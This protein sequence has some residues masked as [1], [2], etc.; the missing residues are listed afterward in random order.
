MNLLIEC[1]LLD[2]KLISVPDGNLY[3]D[4][5]WFRRIPG[6]IDFDSRIQTFQ[7]FDPVTKT[8]PQ[9]FENDTI[10]VTHR[11]P[12][13][14]LENIPV[15][16]ADA[17][18]TVPAGEYKQ[19]NQIY[20]DLETVAGG[21]NKDYTLTVVKN[22]AGAAL[23]NAMITGAIAVVPAT[24]ASIAMFQNGPTWLNN[25]GV[26][27]NED[28]NIVGTVLGPGD[29]I[30]GTWTNKVADDRCRLQVIAIDVTNMTV[31]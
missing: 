1:F 18:Y 4:S 10:K 21:A 27:A 13:E 7:L 12:L 22:I 17:I 29:T 3:D 24:D 11:D 5:R 16:N 23:V 14:I 8:V 9:Y 30:T 6:F 19:I 31:L 26:I 20:C 15:N 25:A 2:R 28:T